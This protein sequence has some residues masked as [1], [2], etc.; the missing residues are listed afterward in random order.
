MFSDSTLQVA[1]RNYHIK[2]WYNIKEYPQLSIKIA[3]P[4]FPSTYL[5]EARLPS[6][7]SKQHIAKD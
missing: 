5:H 2:L 3:L 4:I 6:H 1:L 7:A